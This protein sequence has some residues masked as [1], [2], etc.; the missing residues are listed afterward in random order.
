MRRKPTARLY[1]E[2]RERE[3]DR[4]NGAASIA[5]TGRHALE[6]PH[7][8][9]ERKT[10]APRKRTRE[11]DIV[12]RKDL[13]KGNKESGLWSGLALGGSIIYRDKGDN[14]AVWDKNQDQG[15]VEI[16]KGHI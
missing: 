11:N 10:S 14:L 5:E 2:R 9:G 12:G 8:G 4:G 3:I 7:H 1:R 15:P 6:S 16:G 13:Q